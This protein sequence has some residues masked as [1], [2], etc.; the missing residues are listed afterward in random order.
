MGVDVVTS[1]GPQAAR[2]PAVRTPVLVRRLALATLIGNAVI[3]VTGAAVR[4]TKS[5]LGCPTWPRCTDASY[6]NTP[7]LGIHGWIEFGNR[8]LSVA[9]AVAIGAVILAAVLTRPRRRSLVLLAALQFAGFAAQGVVGGI[10]VLTGLNPWTVAA[11]FLVSMALIYGAYA[12]WHRSGEGDGPPVVTVP[13]PLAWLARAIAICAGAVLVAGTVVTGTGPHSGDQAA[14]RT[15]FDPALVSQFHADLVFLL[16]GLTA[17]AVL[18]FPAGS[19]PRTA[20]L[21]LLA[22]EL[23]QGAVGFVQYFLHLPVLVVALHVAGAA[24]LWIAACRTLFLTRSR[25]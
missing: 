5:G 14:A 15:G 25:A 12:L 13:A 3:V 4:L 6:T 16:V 2:I 23:A 19:R 9:L 8:L 24:A 1:A 11:H 7:E 20:V 18:A 10:T 21:V 22:V 17:A